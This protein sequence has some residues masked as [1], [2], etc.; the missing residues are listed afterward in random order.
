M[1][2]TISELLERLV[3]IETKIDTFQEDIKTVERVST[4]NTNS[5]IEMRQKC[6]TLERDIK[7]LQEKNMWSQRTVYGAIATS[8]GALV[9]CL[10]KIGLG[11][12]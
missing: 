12:G 6:D 3:R 5:I 10:I 1:D 11:V 2:N 4:N 9:L 7:A 8:I